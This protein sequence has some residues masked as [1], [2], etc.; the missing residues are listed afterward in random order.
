M[1]HGSLHLVQ[2]GARAETSQPGR[3]PAV[4]GS[5]RDRKSEPSP[6]L[7]SKSSD[8]LRPPTPSSPQVSIR[9]NDRR[10]TF[11]P[12]VSRK[13]TNSVGNPSTPLEWDFNLR[14]WPVTN[15]TG[16]ILYFF[17]VFADSARPLLGRRRPRTR[18]DRTWRRVPAMRFVVDRQAAVTLRVH[19]RERTVREPRPLLVQL[20]HARPNL[21]APPAIPGMDLAGSAPSSSP[22]Y[23]RAQTSRKAHC[24]AERPTDVTSVTRPACGSGR[25]T[26]R[27]REA[28]S[29]RRERGVEEPAVEMEG[30]E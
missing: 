27:Y 7:P 16:T 1:T 20:R 24:A 14:T 25:T 4:L 8:G 29:V 21:P 17:A 15:P 5:P 11:T 9:P 12:A 6:E 30:E 13:V 10:E 19:L 18:R 26:T 3:A 28:R 23:A 2:P 22:R